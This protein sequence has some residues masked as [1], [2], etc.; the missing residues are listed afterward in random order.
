MTDMQSTIQLDG[1]LAAW[2]SA[3]FETVLKSAVEQLDTGCL[4]LQQALLHSSYASDEDIKL[5]ITS[6]AEVSG[7]IQVKAGVFYSGIIAGCSCA[8]DPT[9]VD[10]CPEYCDIQIDIN[11]QTAAAVIRLLVS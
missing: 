7:V 6:A 5:V 10:T 8:D 9:P 4:P 11:M 1:A 3:A 2:G